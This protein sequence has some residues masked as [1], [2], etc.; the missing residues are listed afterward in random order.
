MID[1]I[2]MMDGTWYEPQTLTAFDIFIFFWLLLL[3]LLLGSHSLSLPHTLTHS[4]WI[5][6]QQG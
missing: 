5:H 1:T 2:N 6:F 3:I 4:V